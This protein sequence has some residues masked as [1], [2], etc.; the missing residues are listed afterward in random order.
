MIHDDPAESAM[1]DEQRQ[2]L[3]ELLRAHQS[4]LQVLGIQKTKFGD[5]TPAQVRQ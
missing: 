3:R 1:E 4:R 5:H 2:K